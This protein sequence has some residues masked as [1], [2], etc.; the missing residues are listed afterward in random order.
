[1]PVYLLIEVLAV[2]AREARDRYR[3]FS[4]QRKPNIT[5]LSDS[6]SLGRRSQI[7]A[8]NR[9]KPNDAQQRSNS[10]VDFTRSALLY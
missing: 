1:M 4:Q 10:T 6:T 8:G 2:Q 3:Q 7:K 9:G 5:A